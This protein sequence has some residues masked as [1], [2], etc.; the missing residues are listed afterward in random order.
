MTQPTITH[1]DLAD[2]LLWVSAG[3]FGEQQAWF[4]RDT[5]KVHYRSDFDDNGEDLPDDI[6]D[7]T[8]YLAL[9]GKR[10]L[11]LGNALALQFAR[12]QLPDQYDDIRD[13]FHHSHAYARYKALLE[14]CDA[15]TAWYAYEARATESALRQWCAD[16]D[17]PLAD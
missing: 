13:T 2:A 7:T 12:E 1:G 10:D 11:D 4:C 9:P 15:L 6:D 8:R 5:G 16:N 14:K 17:L 3:G